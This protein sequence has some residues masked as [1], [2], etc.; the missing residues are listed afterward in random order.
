MPA[1]DAA[2]AVPAAEQT[3]DAFDLRQLRAPPDAR[4]SAVRPRCPEARSGE[5]VVC[6]PDPERERLRPLPEGY[7]IPEG[8]PRLEMKLDE[9]TSADVH[10]E[11]Q[12]FPNGTVSNRLMVGLK[13][14]F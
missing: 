6:A 12:V 11:A 4:F 8:P 10:L 13:K 7:D 14:K 9:T 1:I 3:I 2:P 5:I